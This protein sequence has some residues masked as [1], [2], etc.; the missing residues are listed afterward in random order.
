[1]FVN[2]SSF[3]AV[4]DAAASANTTTNIPVN[5]EE[6]QQPEGAGA[7]AEAARPAAPSDAEAAEAA[8]AAAGPA[9]S[10]A[11]LVDR[12]DG[13]DD[14]DDDDDDVEE[15]LGWAALAKELPADSTAAM[16]ALAAM[17]TQRRVELRSRNGTLNLRRKIN[18]EAVLAQAVGEVNQRACSSC[19]EGYGPFTVCVVVPG[20]MSGSCANCHYNSSGTRC[21]LRRK[22]NR[23]I[24]RGK[25]SN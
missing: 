15:L 14:D 13:G 16:R 3:I 8:M 22:C 2:M 24:Y 23:P 20:H 5:G 12:N 1:M 6:G 7:A 25:D 17:E 9:N 10:E 18:R 4:N 21:N 11:A 19:S